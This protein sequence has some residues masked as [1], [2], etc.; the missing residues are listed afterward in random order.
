MAG[1]IPLDKFEHGEHAE[2]S[3]HVNHEM[4]DLRKRQQATVQRNLHNF[5]QL[6]RAGFPGAVPVEL[7]YWIDSRVAGFIAKHLLGKS[8]VKGEIAT[9]IITA[10][11]ASGYFL[12]YPK[13][14]GGKTNAGY[15]IT[16]DGT[17]YSEASWEAP[18]NA[19]EVNR[20]PHRGLSFQRFENPGTPL[21][22]YKGPDRYHGVRIFEGPAEI[23]E[24]RVRGSENVA[25][26]FEGVAKRAL[27]D[28]GIA[29]VPLGAEPV[30]A[31]PAVT[32]D[33]EEMPA[34][35][36]SVANEPPTVRIPSL[37]PAP[38]EDPRLVNPLDLMMPPR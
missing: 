37:S 22:E 1:Y 26:S 33:T 5:A 24:I 14:N 21:A 23:E 8:V 4:A 34:V 35:R 2:H 29:Y 31:N 12:P 38:S 13:K 19:V 32:G 25:T 16:A 27:T 7:N 9:R 11:V 6:R 3:A 28:A 18:R 30:A 17:V 10:D 36:P 20:A 15:A